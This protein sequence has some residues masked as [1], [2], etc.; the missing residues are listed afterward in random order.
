[1]GRGQG[2]VVAAVA[3]R[4]ACHASRVSPHCFGS[5]VL[6]GVRPWFPRRPHH[7]RRGFRA[8][9]RR[10]VTPRPR[11]G[12]ST[13]RGVPRRGR[14]RGRR[15][16]ADRDRQVRQGE[17]HAGG[18]P[19]HDPTRGHGGQPRAKGAEVVS[20]QRLPR[21]TRASFRIRGAGA[22]EQS[23]ESGA[24]RPCCK[25]VD[26]RHALLEGQR[27]VAEPQGCS[28]GGRTPRGELWPELQ[29]ERGRGGHSKR[30]VG[31]AGS[32]HLCAHQRSQVRG[33]EAA[34]CH[35]RAREDHVD[36]RG[37]GGRSGPRAG[38]R[39]AKQGL[40]RVRTPM[41]PSTSFGS[42]SL[43][44]GTSTSTVSTPPSSAL[45]V[46]GTSYMSY[47]GTCAVRARSSSSSAVRRRHSSGAASPAAPASA[48]CGGKAGQ[49]DAA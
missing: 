30:K 19:R 8:S 41:S 7:V 10:L 44:P 27:V 18:Q 21:V 6:L 35:E 11:A 15:R 29:R 20:T 13:S 37:W 40:G 32:Q 9:P 31:A 34:A 5:A 42:F 16:H 45:I 14:R 25:S 49:P 39:A 38:E 47:C 3:A 22:G 4:S 2:R 36:W 28:Q 43:A 24:P 1:M 33:V 26:C 23:T 46:V 12:G 48:C 17:G